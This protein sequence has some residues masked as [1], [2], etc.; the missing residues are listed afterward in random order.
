M[1]Y[2]KFNDSA[3]L[4]LCIINADNKKHDI[5]SG[6]IQTYYTAKAIQKISNDIKALLILQAMLEYNGNINIDT[7]DFELLGK[8]R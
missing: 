2:V 7:I 4:E 6:I 8:Y 1:A 5:E 3:V